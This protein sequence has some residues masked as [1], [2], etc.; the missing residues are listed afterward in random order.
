MKYY[1]SG[2][3]CAVPE[4]PTLIKLIDKTE[5]LCGS[6]A[7]SLDKQTSKFKN[8]PFPDN[9][10]TKFWSTTGI[11]IHEILSANEGGIQIASITATQRLII[12][13]EK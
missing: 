2:E 9:N 8:L 5:L 10:G 11:A 12:K 13:F 7:L 4:S 6:I 1:E 3:F